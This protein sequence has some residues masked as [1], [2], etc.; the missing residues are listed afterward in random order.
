MWCQMR[1]ERAD[2]CRLLPVTAIV[3]LGTVVTS[4]GVY[5]QRSDDCAGRIEPEAA[6]A[7]DAFAQAQG[8]RI[9]PNTVAA[10]SRSIASEVCKRAKNKPLSNLK[11]AARRSAT[12]YFSSA[13]EDGTPAKI[14]SLVVG[15]LEGRHGLG[16]LD[17]RSYGL[18][19]LSCEPKS[20]VFAI[21][22]DDQ[23]AGACGHSLLLEKGNRLVRITRSGAIVCSGSVTVFAR[24]T[25]TCV[26][27]LASGGSRGTGTPSPMNCKRRP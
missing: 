2:A 9:L 17:L 4:S 6:A 16:R 19:S 5:G 8:L 21:E 11:S 14:A 18:L 7:A 27:T 25:S 23:D 20:E 15:F 26:C 10:I 24:D 3:L 12:S 1:S 13:L 22:V